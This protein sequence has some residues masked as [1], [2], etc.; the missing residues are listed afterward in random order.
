MQTSED[1]RRYAVP[2]EVLNDVIKSPDGFNDNAACDGVPQPTIPEHA[3]K[4]SATLYVGVRTSCPF[5]LKVEQAW[6]EAGGGETEITAHSPVT[7]LD[8]QLYC[9]GS[10]PV[11]CTADTG[12]TIYIMN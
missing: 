3:T 2:V 5:A 11:V 12:A 6:I 7:K 10:S 4:C 9:T 8:Y 1:D